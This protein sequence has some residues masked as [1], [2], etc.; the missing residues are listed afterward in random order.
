M[1]KKSFL[2]I[3]T[4]FSGALCLCVLFF[5][6]HKKASR[7]RQMVSVFLQKVGKE[8][9]LEQRSSDVVI[10]GVTLQ[11]TQYDK[12]NGMYTINVCADRSYFSRTSDVITCSGIHCNLNNDKGVFATFEADVSLVN[13]AKKRM[14]FPRRITGDIEE[15]KVVGSNV[16]FDLPSNQMTFQNPIFCKHPL[17][18]LIASQGSFD[19]K[20]KK[21]SL[22]NGIRTEFLNSSTRNNSRN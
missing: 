3:F 17:F 10:H 16:S 4:S 12:R 21:L 9:V 7:Y 19:I 22:S 13:R 8:N 6:M 2:Y 11:E 5:F 14:F 1:I 15:F 18:S 20:N